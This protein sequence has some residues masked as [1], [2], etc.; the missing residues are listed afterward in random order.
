MKDY[1]DLISDES[2]D[3]VIKNGD[4]FTGDP[5]YNHIRTIIMASPGDFR[6]APRMGGRIVKMKNGM[7]N[8]EYKRYLSIQLE[9]DNYNVNTL[10]INSE[11]E[12]DIDA[13]RKS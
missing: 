2:F 13:H 12:I 3:L 7:W 11:G 4:L 5:D 10:H 8:H 9:S 1:K 6:F